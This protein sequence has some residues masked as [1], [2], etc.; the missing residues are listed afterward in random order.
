MKDKKTKRINVRISSKDYEYLK[1]QYKYANMFE[2]RHKS[3]S[4]YIRYLLEAGS[5]AV[6]L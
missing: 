6:Y 2:T 3:F 5:I 1:K 4:D